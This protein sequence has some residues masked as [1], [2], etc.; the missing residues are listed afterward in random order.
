MRKVADF[1]MVLPQFLPSF[2]YCWLPKLCL[3]DQLASCLRGL[4]HKTVREL[5]FFVPSRLAVLR[6][7]LRL[8][9]GVGLEEPG[10]F[11][12]S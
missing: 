3:I 6:Q 4:S 11:K 8:I 10:G 5:Q 7:S 9:L 2:G 1:L 12:T